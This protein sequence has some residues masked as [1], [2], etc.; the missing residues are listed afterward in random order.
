M[1]V[2]EV[3]Q[4]ALSA[5]RT[6]NLGQ[7]E[8]LY[9]QALA[10]DSRQFD[11]LHMLGVIQHQRRNYGE[12]VRLITRA[13]EVEPRSAEAYADL[14]RV[15]FEMGDLERATESYLRSLAL[16]PDYTVALTNYGALLRKSG[17]PRDALT[18]C[19]K[20][21]GLVADDPDALRHRAG[22]LTDLARYEEALAS[23]DRV[24]RLAPGDAEA[25]L[26]VAVACFALRRHDD[27]RAA[28]DKAL[29]LKPHLPQAWFR[30]G[31]I[32]SAQGSH[33][34]ALAAY[35][36]SLALDPQLADAWRG[37]AS[38]L[39]AQNRHPDA[40]VA[41]EKLLA[42]RPD[43]EYAQGLRLLARMQVCD[44]SD[45]N[46]ECER[47]L[48]GI[49]QDGRAAHPSVLLAIPA[50]ASDQDRCARAYTSTHHPPASPPVW[51]GERYRR[52]KVNV[53]YISSAFRDRP[54]ARLLAGLIERHDRARFATTAISLGP[55][56]GSEMRTRL[57]GAFD[58]FINVDRQS[59]LETAKLLR[60][61]EI[62]IAVDL[63][64]IARDSRPGILAWRPAPIQARWLGYPGTTGADYIDY[65][66]ADRFV[67][68]ADQRPS[69]CE[70]VVTLPE[71]CRPDD[72]GA[73]AERTPTRHEAGLPERGFVFCAFNQA[74]RITPDVF[75]VWM[76]LLSTVDDSVLWLS[77]GHAAAS[78]NLRAEAERRGVYGERLVFAPRLAAHEDH[79]ARHRL[80]GLFLDTLPCNAQSAATDA[81][82][83]GLPVVTCMGET[84]A[85][86][87]CGSMLHAA[88]LP[89]LATDS[90]GEYEAL[91]LKL[92]TEPTML[93]G[94]AAKLAAGRDTCALFDIDRFRRHMEAAYATMRERH[95]RGEPPE[96]F[97]VA[98]IEA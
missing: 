29:A 38:V 22:A 33:Y 18:H 75:D 43:A 67:V 80:A 96:D 78:A 93:Q 9:N 15:Q 85:G 89:E 25:W 65:I 53:A 13:L 77:A 91:A 86:R 95:L 82:R 28:V 10:A 36:K 94:F 11:A 79:L 73:I 26:G 81:L 71:P 57:K 83:A 87:I 92:A 32:L 7:A 88:G 2:A 50:T 72:R 12:A 56:D 52:D 31:N 19:D 40:V 16:N 14:G 21:L 48:A 63:M 4:R 69:Y 39:T 8:L 17:R 24:L 68:P 27:A 34:E 30:L 98:A 70:R 54:G 66:V 74:I 20:A 60:E 41:Y 84:F 42:M 49:R 76:R 62:D 37:R 3:L 5:Y 61:L 35:D 97:T 47:V 1:N 51:R 45:W 64:G 23:Y 59:D 44:W 6:G 55:D 58:R 90:L 46:A